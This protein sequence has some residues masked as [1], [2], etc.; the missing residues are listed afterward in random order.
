MNLLVDCHVFD[1]AHQGTR[2]YLKGLYQ[3]LIQLMPSVDFF[4]TAADTENLRREFGNHSNV[5]YIPLRRKKLVRLVL[6][7]PYLIRKHRIDYAHFQYVVPPLKLCQYIVTTHDV[8]FNDFPGQFS[9]GYRTSKNFLFKWSAKMADLFFTVSLYSK[10][11][12]SRHYNIPLKNI[13][14]TPN[15]VSQEFFNSDVIS[16]H[17]DIVKEFRL[18]KFILFVSRIEPR[19][20]H[21][22]LLQAFNELKLWEKGHSL[23]FVGRSD[24]PYPALETYLSNC[25]EDCRRN[26]HHIRSLQTPDLIALYRQAALS[27]YPSIAEGFG[28]PPLESIAAGTLVLCS[29]TTGMSEFVF[30]NE[31]MFNP[32][33]VEELKTLLAKN[34]EQPTDKRKME[35]LQSFVLENYTWQNSAR[36]FADVLV[37]HDDDRRK[38]EQLTE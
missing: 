33:N 3:E 31:Y 21:L 37:T 27:V 32:L 36:K 13:F 7:F 30:L 25:P 9:L 35:N 29:N 2:T 1:E 14:V 38:S 23:I 15:G 5:H 18:E 28:I 22:A 8:L 10:D 17:S 26:T 11:S 34:L 19:K 20:N 12:I 6:E 16:V 24:L 4:F